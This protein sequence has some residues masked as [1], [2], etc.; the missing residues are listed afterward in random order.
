MTQNDVIIRPINL[1]SDT[2]TLSA[3][4]L[5]ASL[6]AH[7]FIGRQLLLEQ[8]LLIED[9]YLPNSET[10]VA[11]QG[12]KSLGFISLLDKFVGGIFVAPGQQGKG[13]GRQ[14]IAYA[15]ERKG[16]LTLEVYTQN[17]QAVSFYTS[18]GFREVSRRP[19]DD[20]GMPFENAR[21]T[22]ST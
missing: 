8:R 2:R 13:V 3:I 17:E 9:K 19:Y 20:E 1:A 22:L 11:C 5:E 18:L 12:N 21:L 16:E 7:P 4:W 15:L 10:L 6:I 14:L